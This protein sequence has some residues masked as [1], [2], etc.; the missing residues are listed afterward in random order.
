[1][2]ITR[3]E[4][5]KSG[6]LGVAGLS[7]APEMVAKTLVDGEKPERSA[8]K[9][10]RKPFCFIQYSDPQF[11]F[12]DEDKHNTRPEEELMGKAV[13]IINQLRPPF[14]I[15]TGDYFHHRRDINETMLY[16]RYVSMISPATRVYMVP[17]NHDF[18]S[19]EPEDTDY[20][21]THFGPD[22]FSFRHERCAFIGINTM[23]LWL[24][25]KAKEQEREQRE[26]LEEELKGAQNCRFIFLFTH[27]P[28]FLKSIDE[29][30]DYFTIQPSVRRDYVNMFKRYGVNAVFCGHKHNQFVAKDGEL[31][32]VTCGAVGRQLGGFH[33]MNLVKVYPDRYEF[34]YIALNEFPNEI[35]Y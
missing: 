3:R 25:D 8:K 18:R 12:T 16:K 19:V 5:L 33:G 22:R 20:Y 7:V 10:C 11:G 15:G 17:G 29:P 2:D 1:M 9:A 27:I 35:R 6:L 13:D 28:F 32:M 31:D 21:A 23:L 14:V 4:F 30:E 26:W 24:G 34:E